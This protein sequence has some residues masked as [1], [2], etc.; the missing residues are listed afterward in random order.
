MD[1]V[2]QGLR[3]V[4]HVFL[5][6]LDT[7]QTKQFFLDDEGYL[8]MSPV[9]QSIFSP[10]LQNT[11]FDYDARK[12]NSG[13]ETSQGSE[14]TPM[15]T[16]NNIPRSESESDH[17][18]NHSP[19]LNMCQRINENDEVFENKYNYKNVQNNQNGAVSNPT[20]ITFDGDLKKPQNISNNYININVP[21]GLVK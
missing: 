6:I 8:Q 10:R 14:L 19:Y 13:I 16:L 3:V 1:V 15:L 7:F 4:L 11:K 12:L 2:V 18:G 5:Y 17:D 9:N 20:Y 21:N